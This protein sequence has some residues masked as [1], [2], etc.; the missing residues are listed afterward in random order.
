METVKTSIGLDFD[1]DLNPIRFD[2]SGANW[3][4]DFLFSRLFPVLYSV[5][6]GSIDLDVPTTTAPIPLDCNFIVFLDW[7]RLG[8]VNDKRSRRKR[9]KLNMLIQ[10]VTCNANI[11]FVTSLVERSE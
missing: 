5:L 8:L 3:S 9:I 10:R 4:G 2:W 1:F 6:C 11:K 7:L